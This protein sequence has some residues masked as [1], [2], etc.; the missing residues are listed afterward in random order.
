MRRSTICQRRATTP[1]IIAP[2]NVREPLLPEPMPWAKSNAHAQPAIE[3]EPRD[4]T[5]RSAAATPLTALL[6]SAL[7]W[8][9]LY[10]SKSDVVDFGGLPFRPSTTSSSTSGRQ[11]VPP[12]GVR[13][14]VAEDEMFS[15]SAGSFATIAAASS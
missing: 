6:A 8:V 4:S 10:Q 14:A 11:G 7:S 12:T 9:H 3:V 2:V 13:G 5:R 1:P 15:L